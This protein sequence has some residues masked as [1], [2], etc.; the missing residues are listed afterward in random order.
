MP[1]ILIPLAYKEGHEIIPRILAGG[2]LSMD[3]LGEEHERR[4]LVW[5]L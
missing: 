5:C 1:F 2:H 4:R 3:G